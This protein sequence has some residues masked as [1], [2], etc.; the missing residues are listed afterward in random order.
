[1]AQQQAEVVALFLYPVK[2][3]RGFQLDSAT[4]TPS[5]LQTGDGLCDRQWMVVD[6]KGRFVTQR[7]YP[8]MAAITPSL[9]EDHLLLT[10]TGLPALAL[11]LKRPQRGE[12]LEVR[13]WDDSVAA[14]DE[15][16]GAAR[17][18]SEALG[19]SGL[20]M[21]RALSGD[22]RSVKQKYLQPGETAGSQFADAFPYLIGNMASLA[23]YNSTLEAH[24]LA[25]VKM[26][27]FR[28]NIVIKGPAAFAENQIAELHHPSYLL[29]HR[30]PC[31]RCPII[32]VNQATGEQSN[33]SEPLVRLRQMHTLEERPGAYF[34]Q[35][36][37]LCSGSNETIRVGDQLTLKGYTNPS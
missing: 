10:K 32:N 23:S 28:P 36:A 12:L 26:Q 19:V 2:S 25:T 16:E 24:G 33:G 1:M 13:V 11:P 14:L 31:Q 18:L 34:G 7:Q 4:L 29:A 20:R 21:V 37:L 15:G 27:R 8:K 3:M 30:K 22:R 17:W 6:S 35:N 5:G 9:Q